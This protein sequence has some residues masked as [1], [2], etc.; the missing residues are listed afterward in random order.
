MEDVKPHYSKTETDDTKT[1]TKTD[2]ELTAAP[3]DTKKLGCRQRL[4]SYSRQD[5]ISRQDE[6]VSSR[7]GRQ[8]VAF[9]KMGGKMIDQRTRRKVKKKNIAQTQKL[10]FINGLSREMSDQEPVKNA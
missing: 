1:V 3:T 6:V 9:T 8:R 5:S 7:S 10:N 2:V 4:I